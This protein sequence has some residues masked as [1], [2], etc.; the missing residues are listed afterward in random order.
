MLDFAR[1]NFELSKT[2]KNG[3]KLVD[4]LKQAWK[5]TGKKPSKLDPPVDLPF[6]VVHVWEWYVDL[7]RATNNGMG[8]SG[9]SYTEIYYWSKLKKIELTQFELDLIADLDKLFIEVKSE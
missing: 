1:W 4:T 5:T 6:E 9:I 8:I 7:S 3:V 2:D